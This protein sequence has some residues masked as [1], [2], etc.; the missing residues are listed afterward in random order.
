MN[1]WMIPL[2]NWLLD[3]AVLATLLLAAGLA[4]RWLLSRPAERMATA[5]S[6]FA[7]LAALVVLT[8][9]PAWP[10]ISLGPRGILSTAGASSVTATL[11]DD[12]PADIEALVPLLESE[13]A[14]EPVEGAVVI[15]SDVPRRESF[16]WGVGR[17]REVV[18]D[19]AGH[20]AACGSRSGTVV[21]WDVDH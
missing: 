15:L 3:Y 12:L 9:L 14:L 7:G 2:A 21:V 19:A 13:D 10:R 20:R 17:V 6:C 5:W 8:A 18:F 16:D 1:A 4:A 11:M